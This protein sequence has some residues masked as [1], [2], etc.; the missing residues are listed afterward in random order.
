MSKST[1]SLSKFLRGVFWLVVLAALIYL[2]VT[3]IDVFGN[4]FLVVLGFGGVILVH[5]FGHFIVAKLSGIKVEAFSVGFPPT[6]IGI[7]RMDGGYRIRI[8]P[9]LFPKED[10]PEDGRLS[11]TIG[12]KVKAGETEY[13]VALIPGGYVKM[14]GQEDVGPVKASD[15][16]RSFAN[17]P[18]AARVAVIAAGVVFN[19]ISAAIVFI[20]VFLIGI[21]LLPPVVGA[22]V[23]DSPAARAGL[24]PGDEV[25]EIDG[26][27]EDLDFS[28]I[29][30]AAALS[31]RGEQVPLKIK[32]EDGSIQDYALVAEQF[33]GAEMRLFGVAPALSLTVAKVSDAD[34]LYRRTG[35]LPRDRINA[36]DGTDVQTYWALEKLIRQSLVPE[37]TL[38]AERTDETGASKLLESRSVPLEWGPA[39]REV[40]SE[41]DLGHIYS[42][43]P[44]LRITAVE[45]VLDR[46]ANV[47]WLS[48][49]RRRLLGGKVDTEKTDD[50][51]GPRLKVEDIILEVAEVEY[52]TFKELRDVTAEYESN[53]LPIQVLRV[54]ANGVEKELEVVVVPKRPPGGDRAL[55][56]IGVALDAEH[57][58]VAKTIALKGD[59]AGLRI[60]RGAA[61]TAVDG[62]GVSDFYDV[63]REIR[64]YPGERVAVDWRL[65]EQVAGAVALDV[66]DPNTFVAVESNWAVP[67]PFEDLK[68]LYQATGPLDAVAMGY[69]RT[70]MFIAQTYLT[71]KRLAGGL[72]SPKNL[73]GPVGIV[74]F[75][76]RIVA[77]QPL[78]YYVY[79]LGIISAF[80]AVFN[81]LP[82][83]PLDGGL[84]VLLLIERIKGSAL[85]ERTQGII[86]YTGWVLIG[87]LF[88]YVT[89][90]DI[91]NRLFN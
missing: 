25:I 77:E 63:I 19:I 48:K 70:V 39:V 66:G 20:I 45:P 28:S 84:I 44:R 53:D 69:K 52:P 54:D 43:V 12:A 89:F 91:V 60:P 30:V 59:T 74:T 49:I 34:E 18:L 6:L 31:D 79:W 80:I 26:E 61:I 42:M 85:S 72:V 73:M 35:L 11:F 14:L 57:P 75:S 37:V 71:I 23:P 24:R 21:R 36:V 33:E 22:V 68:R 8:L 76:Y 50:D 38:G 27:S 56:G 40:E 46:Q 47:S 67:I 2:I 62:I 1:G 88:L 87:A 82:L 81:F 29:A 58:I 51:A 15:D 17:K 32:R 13:R 5:E 64:R 83:P 90:N 86:A 65:D 9:G 10:D 55:I 3:K 41:S 16:P 4:I 78:V 7:R